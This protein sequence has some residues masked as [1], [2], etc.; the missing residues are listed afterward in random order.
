MFISLWRE[1]NDIFACFLLSIQGI[2]DLW[3]LY[4]ESEVQLRFPGL[5]ATNVN[6]PKSNLKTLYLYVMYYMYICK[7]EIVRFLVLY[8]CKCCKL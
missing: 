6:N 8:D 1:T 2:I 5:F 7:F 3:L 4:S